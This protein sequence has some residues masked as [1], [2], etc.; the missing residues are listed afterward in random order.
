VPLALKAV[1]HRRTTT[2]APAARSDTLRGISD[3]AVVKAGRSDKVGRAAS[4][5]VPGTATA[6]AKE[7]LSRGLIMITPFLS[8][9]GRSLAK[10][11]PV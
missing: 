4:D 8:G 7:E 11:P 5:A 3:E 9:P 2:H 6:T 10:V 1:S